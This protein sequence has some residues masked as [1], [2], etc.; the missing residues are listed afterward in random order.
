M[1]GVGETIRI[2][3]MEVSRN[4]VAGIVLVAHLDI[5]LDARQPHLE[6]LLKTRKSASSYCKARW[7]C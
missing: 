7:T 5:L 2:D 3:H 1:S 4:G 6:C